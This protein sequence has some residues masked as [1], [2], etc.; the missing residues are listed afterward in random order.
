MLSQNEWKP[1]KS[2]I[3]G[4]ATN[5]KIPP[6]DK[7]IRCVNFAG[8]KD[9]DIP[10]SGY[11]PQQV[12]D[13]ANEDLEVLCDFLKKENIKV[14]RPDNEPETSYYNYCPRDSVI[15]YKNKV[16][17][18]PQ[19]L[20]ARKK[21]YKNLEGTLKQTGAEII[22]LQIERADELYNKACL[23]NKDIL[24]LTESEP[25]FDAAN[26]LKANDE[27]LYL[28]SNSG[29]EVGA[30][31]LQETL[32]SSVNVHKI[33]GVYSFMHIDSTITLLREG[34]VLLNPARV[35][36]IYDLPSFMHNWD[37]VWCPQPYDIGHYPG[38]CNAS[39]WLN[40]N[41]LSV[42]ENLVVLEQHQHALRKELE[43]Y[44]IDCAMLPGRHQ[45]TLGGGFHCVT[46]D[47]ERRE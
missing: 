5:A 34:L 26:V 35:K 1:L 44:K 25:A 20:R 28:V 12:I 6:V 41:L 39:A 22:R 37:V 4:T 36:S 14:H 32:G 38:Y 45:R 8:E 2:V 31:L 10:T 13:E 29:N 21:D 3:V 23:R 7:S 15:T 19:P 40:M 33:K 18:C 43:K 16:I 30:N 17:C 11:Y 42:N 46:L 9:E 27:I 24:A 47:I